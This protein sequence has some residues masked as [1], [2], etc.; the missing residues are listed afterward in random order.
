MLYLPALDGLRALAV[1]AVLLYHAGLTRAAGGF[2]GVD[3][4][5]VLSG[6]LIT[7]LLLGEHA[8]EGRISFGRFWSRRARRLLPA[9]FLMLGAVAVYGALL[10]PPGSLADLR[11]QALATLAYGANWN[12]I[13]SGQGYFAQLAAPSPLLHTWSLA[14]EEQFYLVWPLLLTALVALGRRGKGDPDGARRGARRLLPLLAFSLAGAA[15]SATA[16]ALLFHG[17]AG[18]NRVYY[19]TDTRSQ[20]LLV[21]AALA[22]LVQM[23]RN[24]WAA[25]GTRPRRV[26]L[27]VA[28][29]AGLAVVVAAS[30]LA[31]G[32]SGWLYRGGFA[33]VAVATAA[34]LGAVALVPASPWGRVLALAPVRYVGRISYGLYLWH[35]PVFLVLDGDRTGLA[36]AALVAVRLAA[37]AVVAVASYHLVE[38][39]IRRGALAHWRAWL[40]APAAAGAVV[41]ALV[42]GTVAPAGAT[43]ASSALTGAGGA[44][45]PPGPT[46]AGAGQVDAGTESLL[47]AVAS[48]SGGPVR[49]LIVGD[50]TATAM[51]LGFSPTGPY[52]VDL[53]TDAVIGCGLMTGG[54]IAN[55]GTVSDGNAGLRT[56][57][58]WVRCDTWPQRWAADVAT[59]HP[60]VVALMEGAWEVRDRYLGHRWVHIGQPAY[61][62]RE[63]ADL[64]RAVGILSGTGARVALLTSPYYSQ[65]EQS[66]GSPQPADQPARVDRYNALL[67]QAAAAFPGR[68]TVV[69]LGAQLSPGGRYAATIGGATVR[70]EDGIHLTTDGARLVEPWLLGSL[71]RLSARSAS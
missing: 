64:E 50:S 4:F 71:R 30:T 43:L 29:G 3:V 56:R 22:A 10:A 42:V 35:W 40:G 45:P 41:V 19:G 36:G 67:R 31:N 46:T 68:A 55:R 18:V 14:I 52:G 9:L 1:V 70:D 37:A 53:Q 61:D 59:F 17:G 33:G 23:R 51:S 21:G 28:G 54:L 20:D 39:P 62:R 16:M 32:S 34:L 65:P 66:D 44:G 13:F 2:L 25:P 48:G 69:G 5:F 57:T 12:Q 7:S 11:R 26:A 58:E 47:P 27:G 24:P 63:L 8:R 6:F 49:V 38:A 15:A 60:D